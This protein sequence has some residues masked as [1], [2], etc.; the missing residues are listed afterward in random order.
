MNTVAQQVRLEESE[1]ARPTQLSHRY[2]DVELFNLFI[3]NSKSII[4]DGTATETPSAM[5][6]LYT[7][8]ELVLQLLSPF[9][10]F[11]PEELWQRLPHRTKSQTSTILM[12]L[13]PEC[14]LS[15]RDSRSEEEAYELVLGSSKCIRPLLAD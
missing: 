11:L 9:M 12:A 8:I 6:T 5:V 4:L 15:F 13:Y 1:F 7:K 3:Y 2:L 14:E 10:P